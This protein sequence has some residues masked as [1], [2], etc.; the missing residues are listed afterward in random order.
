MCQ[1]A[2]RSIVLASRPRGAPVAENFRLVERPC[3]EL[4]DGQVLL[5]TLWLSLDPYMRGS[6]DAAASY[7]PNVELD[8]PMPSLS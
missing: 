4:S 5:R 8:Q 6:M 7:A 2:I 1:R 3:P